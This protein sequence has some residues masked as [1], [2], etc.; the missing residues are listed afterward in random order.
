MNPQVNDYNILTSFVPNQSGTALTIGNFD[1][2]HLGHAALIQQLRGM[3]ARLKIPSV[4]LTFDPHPSSILYPETAAVP[5][6]TI[7]RRSELLRRLGVEHVVVCPTNRELLSL[8]AASFFE[9][10]V[11]RRLQ[12]RG[13]IEGPNF[14]FGR[15]RQG[16]VERLEEMCRGVK[17]DF[18]VAQPKLHGETLVSSTRIRQSLREGDIAATNAWLTEPYQIAGEVVGGEQRGRKL[19]FPTANLDQIAVLVPAPGVYATT[20]CIQGKRYAAATHIGPNPTFDQ[21]LQKIEVHVLDYHGDLYGQLLPVDFHA[22]V[23]DIARFPSVDALREQLQRDLAR[24]RNETAKLL[25][26]EMKGECSR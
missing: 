17:I 20:V 26:S 13:L 18:E 5:L 6:T 14:Y 8:D 11:Y 1:G 4:V 24:V 15:G 7:A 2:V 10:I 3:A 25:E 22:R 21:P 12:A 9:Q 19:G 16:N 23:R